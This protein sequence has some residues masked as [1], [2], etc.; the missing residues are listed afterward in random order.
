MYVG[1]GAI[2]HA[3]RPGRRVRSPVPGRCRFSGWCG[4]TSEG[5]LPRAPL[6]EADGPTVRLDRSRRSTERDSRV[7]FV[8]VRGGRTCRPRGDVR[9]SAVLPSQVK[10]SV[11]DGICQERGAVGHSLPL[12]ATAMVASRCPV[13][14]RPDRPP[15]GG[16]TGHSGAPFG[17]PAHP[18]G[19]EG[20]R[21]CPYRY[22]ASGRPCCRTRRA[23]GLHARRRGGHGGSG[24]HGGGA[25]GHRRAGA[26][27]AAH[28]RG[29]HQ[30]GARDAGPGRPPGPR[31]YG[32]QPHRGGAALTDDVHCI[33]LDLAPAGAGTA[34]CPRRTAA[35]TSWA[36]CARC[37]GSPRP[38]RPR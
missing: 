4:R 28:R 15:G 35:P 14:H 2:V 29:P 3:P 16:G 30:L 12:G 20:S 24:G 31:P 9:H 23:G 22:R 38:R 26:D 17:G 10:T 7:R 37:C 34:W 21:A 5:A 8:T 11:A 19:R 27:P 18:R 32:P 25:R 6:G 1:D 13:A 36:P 33:L